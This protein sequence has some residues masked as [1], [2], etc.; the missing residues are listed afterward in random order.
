MFLPSSSLET[1]IRHHPTDY[2]HISLLVIFLKYFI[3]FH[4]HQFWNLVKMPRELLCEV[5]QPS[6]CCLH[7]PA[8]SIG[9]P[10]LLLSLAQSSWGQSICWVK[11]K[12][13][14]RSYNTLSVVQ[15][16]ETIIHH[17]ASKKGKISICCA[18]K[19]LKSSAHVFT[20][21]LVHRDSTYLFIILFIIHFYSYNYCKSPLI[22]H[23]SC[24][25]SIGGKKK[26]KTCGAQQSQTEN[27]INTSVRADIESL[28]LNQSPCG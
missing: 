17:A 16:I 21:H 9:T 25:P 5:M 12:A 11:C 10:S 6:T 19:E 8:P 3:S 14:E 23:L 18:F 27:N 28:D 13:K 20:Q 1:G 15:K 7:T 22:M 24:V 26:T 2:H 4:W